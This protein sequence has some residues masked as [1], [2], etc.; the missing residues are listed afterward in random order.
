MTATGIRFAYRT[1]ADISAPISQ[2]LATLQAQQMAENALSMALH[3]LRN[4][5]INI[6]GATRKTVQA[7]SALHQVQVLMLNGA[8]VFTI[9]NER[10]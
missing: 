7:L 1:S 5:A 3:Y 2:E 8:D 4:S 9:N 10:G 6:P